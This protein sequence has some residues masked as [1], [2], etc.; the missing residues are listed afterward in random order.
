MLSGKFCAVLAP[1]ATAFQPELVICT[2]WELSGKTPSDQAD[3]LSQLPLVG[4]VQALT[5]VGESAN[6]E[7][8]VQHSTQ[9]SPREIFIELSLLSFFRLGNTSSALRKLNGQKTPS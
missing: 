6:T 2:D 1:M 8:E 3:A 4:L 9:S 7:N 5:V